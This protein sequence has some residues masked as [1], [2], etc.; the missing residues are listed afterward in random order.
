MY[1]IGE[2]KGMNTKLPITFRLIFST[3]LFILIA[4]LLTTTDV[5]SADPLALAQVDPVDPVLTLV[6]TINSD[7]GGTAV[8]TAWTLTASG[9]TT[10]ISGPTGDSA[11]TNVTVP[12]GTYNLSESSVAGYSLTS[13]TCDNNSGIQVTSVTLGYYQNVTCTFVNDDDAPSLKLAKNVTND[14]GGTAVASA[15]TLYAGTDSVTGSETAVE[16]T[17]QVGTYALTESK[18]AGYSLTSLT[19]DDNPSVQVTSVTIGLG[20]TITCTF[21]NDDVGFNITPTSGLL[22]SESGVPTATFTVVLDT[23]PTDNVTLSLA[24]SN[25]DEGTIDKSSLTFTT[26]DW[27]I[28]QEV[29]VTGVE[30][31]GVADGDQPY[32]I[33]T[34]PVINTTDADYLSLNPGTIIPD[35]SVINSDNDTPGFTVTPTTDLWVSEGGKTETIQVLL[36]SKPT[37]QVTLSVQSSDT[38]EEEGV[39]TIENA[40]VNPLPWPQTTPTEITVTGVDDCESGVCPEPIQKIRFYRWVEALGANVTI[41]EDLTPPYQEVLLPIE[42][43][44][45]Y[46]QIS[47]FAFSPSDPQ[48]FSKHKYIFIYM[49][50]NNVIHLPVV[51]K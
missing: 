21:V 29:T 9:P 24:S 27:N 44:A 10:T 51:N 12:V 25:T 42:L 6:K 19:C 30:D 38:L 11:V 32:T 35:V 16:V 3:A 7:N 39:V 18:V 23:L 8:A 34:G 5:Q 43:Q 26:S 36:K 1:F 49:G 15:W 28:P 45:E 46:N 47:A 14:N 37:S 33:V 17:D 22:T 48:T 4:G 31:D 41:G 20:E 50:F 40:V 2:R 13:L